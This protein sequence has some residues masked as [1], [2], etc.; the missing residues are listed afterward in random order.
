MNTAIEA[1]LIS[2]TE[3][4]FFRDLP[5]F[6]GARHFELEPIGDDPEGVFARLRCSDPVTTQGGQV[7]ENL[8]LLVMSPGV[9]WHDYEVGID[10]LTVEQLGISKAED[11]LIIAI[12]HPRDPLSSS[13]A[14]LYSPIVVN[15]VNGLADQ[16]VPA[17]S[18]R[19]VG[20][21]VRT[22][23]PTEEGE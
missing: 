5:G 3:L 15:R 20:W 1:G 2:K 12:V 13:T 11:V 18:E 16:L 7:L 17:L 10:E 4:T 22:P 9:L 8:A 6:K 19:E 23:F 14:N 21:S